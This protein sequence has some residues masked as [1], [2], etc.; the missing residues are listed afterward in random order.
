[1]IDDEVS[2]AGFVHRG[3]IIYRLCYTADT[4]AGIMVQLDRDGNDLLGTAWNEDPN[5]RIVTTKPGDRIWSL[6][7]WNTIVE[8]RVWTALPVE[9]AWR[10]GGA[11]ARRFPKIAQTPQRRND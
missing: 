6:G 8:V 7:K 4:G 2:R 9:P 11:G 3:Q 10:P 5:R 1:M